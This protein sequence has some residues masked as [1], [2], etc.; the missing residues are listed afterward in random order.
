VSALTVAAVVMPH[1]WL[2]DA[3][4]NTEIIRSCWTAPEAFSRVMV[5]NA[6]N[7]NADADLV[8]READLIVRALA[9]VSSSRT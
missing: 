4:A 7:G 1:Y 3:R 6:Y 8:G 2:D 5:V 9:H